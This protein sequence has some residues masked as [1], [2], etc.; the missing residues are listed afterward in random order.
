MYFRITVTAISN[1]ILWSSSNRLGSEGQLTWK[2]TQRISFQPTSKQ[3]TIRLDRSTSHPWGRVSTTREQVASAITRST[4]VCISSSSRPQPRI[5]Q[6]WSWWRITVQVRTTKRASLCRWRRRIRIRIC[7]SQPQLPCNRDSRSML[8]PVA[9]G[10]N[11]DIRIEDL[12]I[13]II[14]QLL[15]QSAKTSRRWL[16]CAQCLKYLLFRNLDR[17]WLSKGTCPVLNPT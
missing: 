11:Q 5:N 6:I 13:T 2:D 7:L 1:P 8:Y 12:R 4:Q 10:S 9:R 3:W 14:A 16:R 15:S 17:I